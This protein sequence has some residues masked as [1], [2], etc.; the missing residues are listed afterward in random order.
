MSH[1]VAEHA[2]RRIDGGHWRCEFILQQ[3][4]VEVSLSCGVGTLSFVSRNYALSD[5]V[6]TNEQVRSLS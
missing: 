6:R 2:S 4:I 3:E 5:A 1:G